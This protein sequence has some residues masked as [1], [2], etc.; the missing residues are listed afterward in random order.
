MTLFSKSLEDL[1]VAF[2]AVGLKRLKPSGKRAEDRAIAALIAEFDQAVGVTDDPKVFMALDADLVVVF[3]GDADG[4]ARLYRPDAFRGNK[5]KFLPDTPCMVLE[6][7]GSLN[8][9]I[10]K[11]MRVLMLAE[12]RVQ[13]MIS[14]FDQPGGALRD[15]IE[16]LIMRSVRTEP[17]AKRSSSKRVF[18]TLPHLAPANLPEPMARFT[19]APHPLRDA[20][21]PQPTP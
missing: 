20:A 21:L 13:I 5:I 4:E 19:L 7:E 8:S 10:L 6:S 17:E 3:D 18:C 16:R 11:D 12:E 9:V 15:G 1:R 14:H 2:V